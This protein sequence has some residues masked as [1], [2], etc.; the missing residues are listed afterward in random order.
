VPLWLGER[1]AALARARARHP[2]V[3][4]DGVDQLW[5]AGE[6]PLSKRHAGDDQLR[7]LAP[8][9]P[10]V[11][12]RRRFTLFWG[13]DYRFEAY[14]PAARRKQGHYALLLL[15]RGQV[16]GWGNLAWRGGRLNARLGYVA[17]RAPREAT[18]QQAL[19]E[20]VERFTAFLRIARGACAQCPVELLQRPGEDHGA[21]SAFALRRLPRYVGT[22]ED[23]LQASALSDPIHRLLQRL[24]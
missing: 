4:I 24:R 9:D 17:G 23:L 7:L 16:I 3:R 14:T 1:A 15:W 20:E 13:W 6:N 5:P 2:S 22:R 8:F 11:W 21:R 19:D 10:I 18:L 12:D